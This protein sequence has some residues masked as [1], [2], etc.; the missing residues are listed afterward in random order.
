MND[1]KIFENNISAEMSAWIFNREWRQERSER[2]AERREN[3]RDRKS[4]RVCE[5]SRLKAMSMGAPWDTDCQTGLPLLKAP[6]TSYSNAPGQPYA[7]AGPPQPPK[8][9]NQTFMIIGA[10][11]VVA[12]IVG[13][14][15]FIKNPK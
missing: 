14:I 8:K 9:N 7:N 11:V 1:N 10:V 4:S 3:R 2:V 6:G 12:I 13:A 5:R 15:Y